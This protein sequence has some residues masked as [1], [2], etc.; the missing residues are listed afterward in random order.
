MTI[1]IQKIQQWILPYTCII[2]GKPSKIKRDL[3][4]A[5]QQDLPWNKH[6]CKQ[7]GLALEQAAIKCGQCLQR[8]PSFNQTLALFRYEDPIDK[9]IVQLKF[10]HK[11]LYIK[12][13]SELMIECLQT[14][15]WDFIPELIIPMPLHKQRLRERGY[16][17][18][19]E[20]AKPLSKSLHI[21]IDI[22]N[23]QRIKATL[24]QTSL[25][26][27]ER[28]RNVKNAFDINQSFKAKSVMLIDDVITSGETCQSFSLALKQAG[29]EKIMLCCVARAGKT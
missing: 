4:Y 18:A 29:V 23:C 6:A 15:Q 28:K 10:Y 27:E 25:P 16:N 7:C 11:F 14:M 12:L 8:S 21:P 22:E 1:L 17:Q 3:C 5:C 26:F 9:F 24:A 19:L 2:C 20:L 13:L